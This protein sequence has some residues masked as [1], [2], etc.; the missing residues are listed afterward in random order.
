MTIERDAGPTVRALRALDLLQAQPGITAADL[1]EQL[2]VTDRAAR[3]YVAILRDAGIP[4]E[5]TP[6]PF[7][8]YRVG[9][10]LRLPPLRFDAAEAMG[11]VMAVLDGHP[12]AGDGRDVVGGALSKIIRALPESIATQ[13]ETIRRGAATVPDRW[14][15]PR[16]ARRPAR[17]PPWSTRGPW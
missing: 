11:V 1:G 5:S 14:A 8:G 6:G 3:R 16:R 9:R 2:G 4:I 12:G 15:A 13:A 17:G 10:G 7:G